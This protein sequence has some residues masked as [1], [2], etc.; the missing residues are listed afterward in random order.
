VKRTKYGRLLAISALAGLPA[1][2]FGQPIACTSPRPDICPGQ[3]SCV[4]VDDEWQVMVEPSGEI[5]L[6]DK[7]VS[8]KTLQQYATSW[9]KDGT[10]PIVV[11]GRTGTRDA[12]I[13]SI[14]SLFKAAGVT[15][16]VSCITPQALIKPSAVQTHG[17]PD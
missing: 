17:L 3:S 4:T 14:V 10:W 7:I 9:A 11:R 15:T 13:K 5:Y 8:R 12:Q 1:Q 2:V 6:N 16:P